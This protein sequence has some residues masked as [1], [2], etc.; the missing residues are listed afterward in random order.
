MQWHRMQV[1]HQ[2]VYD[3]N[4]AAVYIATSYLYYVLILYTELII[5]LFNTINIAIANLAICP[6]GLR[7]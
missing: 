5:N 2:L 1:D 6:L 4:S 7:S 3:C